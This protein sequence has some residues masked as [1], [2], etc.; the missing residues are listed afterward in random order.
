MSD[1]QNELADE[2]IHDEMIDWWVG[3]V[4]LAFI[5]TVFSTIIYLLINGKIDINRMI[6]DGELVLS[7][8]LITTPTLISFTKENIYQR[9]K[10][11]KK[12]LFYLLL[13]TS[14]FQLV[15]Y[16]A[17]KANPSNSP[18]IV[19]S[20]SALCVIS[21]II[22]SLLGEIVRKGVASK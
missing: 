11:G 13:F 9:G 21:S 5:P 2:G 20:T 12:L 15:A 6:G 18:V 19:Y 10:R 7:A 3:T 14:F 4:L 22:I 17:I 1:S 8:F 16:T